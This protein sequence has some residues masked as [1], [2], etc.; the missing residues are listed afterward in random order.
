MSVC[1]QQR[2]NKNVKTGVYLAPV[3]VA[4]SEL[5]YKDSYFLKKSRIAV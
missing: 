2:S 1:E 4:L 3:S 5:R